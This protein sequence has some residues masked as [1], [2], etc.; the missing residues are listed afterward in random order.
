MNKVINIVADT[1]KQAHE[2]LDISRLQRLVYKTIRDAGAVGIHSDEVRR[3]LPDLA[4]SSVTA[5]YRALLDKGLVYLPG[6][7]RNGDSGRAQRVMVADC[8]RRQ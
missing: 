3:R 7:T 2:T 1:S 6:T 8:W 4:Y 5:R